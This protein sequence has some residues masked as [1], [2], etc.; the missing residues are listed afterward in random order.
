MLTLTYQILITILMC[1]AG[2]LL[3]SVAFG[4]LISKLLHK[5]IR[6]AGSGNI[7]ATNVSRLLGF[8]FGA[9]VMVLD[10]LKAYIVVL[11]NAILIQV[12]S[13]EPFAQMFSVVVL[14]YL[15]GFFVI[16]GHCYP[17]LYILALIKKDPNKQTK[18]GGKGVSSTFGLLLSISPFIA[19]IF[20]VVWLI[21]TFSTRYVCLGSIVSCFI[22]SF[23]IFIPY[24][25]MLY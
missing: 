23:L 3:G 10:A 16:L 4:A 7:G 8:K 19:F 25:N 24:I 22:A 11:L 21:V 2:Y 20:G 13:A 6:H 5:D 12:V 14:I 18:S 1:I 17:L 15:P 9:L